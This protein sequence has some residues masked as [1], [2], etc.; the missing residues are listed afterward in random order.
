MS[1]PFN[2]EV[3]LMEWGDCEVN[4]D[5]IEGDPS[6]GFDEYYEF[7]VIYAGDEDGSYE[8]TDIVD[9]L[10]DEELEQVI[11]AIKQDLNNDK[12]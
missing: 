7:E 1:F 6:V 5:V 11:N 3:H 2:T 12:Y 8:N 4:Y 10:S 9:K